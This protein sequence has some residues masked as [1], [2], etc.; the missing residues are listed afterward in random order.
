MFCYSLI[1]NVFMSVKVCIKLEIRLGK[2]EINSIFARY[3]D[4]SFLIDFIKFW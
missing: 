3:K 1:K 2:S 4:R